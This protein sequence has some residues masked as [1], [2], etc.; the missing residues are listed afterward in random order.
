MWGTQE[1]TELNLL[2]LVEK[3]LDFKWGQ[4]KHFHNKTHSMCNSTQVSSGH[5]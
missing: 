2:L 1:S 5:S 4:V 3:N